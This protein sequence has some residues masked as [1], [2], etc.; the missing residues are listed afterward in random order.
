M[1][2]INTPGLS[3]RFGRFQRTDR[4]PSRYIKFRPGKPRS[5]KR[6]LEIWGHGGIK[7]YRKRLDLR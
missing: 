5:H 3:H 4:V 6:E 7:K 1:P 2:T